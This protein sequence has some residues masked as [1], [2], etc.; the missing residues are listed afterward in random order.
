MQKI[1][2][3]IKSFNE[4]VRR[5][6]TEFIVMVTDDDPIETDFLATM[7][8]LY[9]RYPNFSAYCGFLRNNKPIMKLKLFRMINL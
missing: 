4:S 1:W 7:F 3:M 8:D 6:Q 9:K 5:S 2:G